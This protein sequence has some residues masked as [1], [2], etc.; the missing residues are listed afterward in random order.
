MTGLLAAVLAKITDP[1]LAPSIVGDLEEE[2]ARRR[3]ASPFRA[4]L[5]FWRNALAIVMFAI[6]V[7]AGA[8]VREQWPRGWGLGAWGREVRPA[9]RSLRRNAVVFGDRD[10]RH[11]A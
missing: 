10:R 5:W 8:I 2:R 9:W 3:V 6:A 7:R 1:A 4:A 11:R